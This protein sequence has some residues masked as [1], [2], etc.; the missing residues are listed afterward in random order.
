[1]SCWWR[2]TSLPYEVSYSEIFNSDSEYYNGSNMGNGN[3]IP[4]EPQPWMSQNHSIVLTLPPLAGVVLR[5][6]N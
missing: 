1:M 2:S 6:I 5:K 4:S 3:H